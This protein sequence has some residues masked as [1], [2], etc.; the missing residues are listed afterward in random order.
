MD[1]V[2]QEVTS[3]DTQVVL[4]PYRLTDIDALVEAVLESVDTLSPWMPWCHPNY[5]RSDAEAW[6]NTRAAAWTQAE[7]YSFLITDPLSGR[8][9]GAAGLN[10]ISREYNMANLGYWIR[11]SARGQGLAPA[12]TR[13][14]ARFGLERLHLNRIEII[15]AVG[16][17]A[18]QRV[19]EKAGA[20]REGL[21]RSR[22]TIHSKP[23]DTVL[24]SF[25]PSD[26]GITGIR[27][28]PDEQ[29]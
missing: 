14:L 16:N 2:L 11:R 3:S 4:R 6:V 1:P 7:D 26:F 19:A 18:S 20:Y 24:F 27:C 17:A 21:L 25:I 10:H 9:L 15:V 12:A 8:M 13:L 29:R 5:S 28:G 23:H 22:L